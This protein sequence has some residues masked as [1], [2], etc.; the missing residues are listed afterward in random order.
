MAKSYH[1]WEK[2]VT[3]ELHQLW[4]HSDKFLICHGPE[5]HIRVWKTAEPFGR[6]KGADMVVLVAS[7]LLHDI[8]SFDRAE[9]HGHEMRSA[10]IAAGVLKK[11]KF[12][13]EKIPAVLSAISEHRSD[14]KV[15]NSLAGRIFKAFDK[16]DAFGPIG[17]YRILLPL[18]IRGYSLEDIIGW[19]FDHQRLQKKWS[20]V[21][22]PELRKKY[23]SR[24]FYTVDY[25]KRLRS[26]LGL[27]KVKTVYSEKKVFA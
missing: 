9:P 13:A 19:A 12:P 6:K 7:C 3:K 16:I 8:S 18:S 14:S 24:Y 11:I 26:L 25:F 2:A 1:H 27:K 15:M 20:S 23:R 22:F 17:V 21:T 4:E 10:R 5:H